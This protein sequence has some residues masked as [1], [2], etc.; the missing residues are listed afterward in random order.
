MILKYNIY[1][2]N[3]FDFLVKFFLEILKKNNYFFHGN[4]KKIIFI[5]YIIIFF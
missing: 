1:Q 4:L 5:N 2:L 3:L